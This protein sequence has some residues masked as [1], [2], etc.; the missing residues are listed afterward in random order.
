MAGVGKR[1]AAPSLEREYER[2]RGVVMGMLGKRFPRFDEDERLAI[3]HDA[4]AR[5]L[6]K[7]ERGEEIESLRA[8]LLATCSAEALNIVSKGRRPTPVAPDEPLFTS[9]PDEGPSLEEH[10]LVKDQAR[11]ARDL[12]GTLDRRQR[13]VLKL[14]W[15]LQLDG[16]EIRAALGLSRRQ[17]QRIAEEGAA[18]IAKRVE[19]LTDGTWSRK[20]RSLLTACLVRVTVDGEESEGIASEGQRREAQR[21]LQSDPHVAALFAEVSGSLRRAAALLPLPLLLP[22]SLEGPSTSL[23]TSVAAHLRDL[24]SSLADTIRQQATSVYIRAADP[25]LLTS[26]RPGTLVATLAGCV[27]VGGGAFGAYDAVSKQP[28]GPVP[29]P[30]P[31]FQTPAR[32]IATTAIPDAATSRHIRQALAPH[33]STNPEPTPTP[34]PNPVA[35]PPPAPTPT[36]QPTPQP[37]PPSSEF[38]FEQ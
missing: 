3:Y 29:T 10:V 8:Y 24:L 34:S 27:A 23:V 30:A 19:Q 7:R 2:C 33:E 26:P 37:S 35:S 31:A 11:L 20:Q 17:Y 22:L 36:V 9:L 14:R 16:A 5:V 12:I 4:W 28:V 25:T 15:D 18:E 13:D 21:L 1:S 6:S 32:P 38:G